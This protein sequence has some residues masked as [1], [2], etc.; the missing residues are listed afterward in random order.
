M[1]RGAPAP[2]IPASPH[3]NAPGGAFS[4]GGP[5]QPPWLV[6]FL[7]GLLLAAIDVTYGVLA[8][9]DRLSSL[10]VLSTTFLAAAA[11]GAGAYLALWYGVVRRLRRLRTMPGFA[12]SVALCVLLTGLTLALSSL[13]RAA[14]SGAL[15]A[16]SVDAVLAL[17]LFGALTPAAYRAASAIEVRPERYRAIL[18]AAAVAPLVA[19]AT[20]FYVWFQTYVLRQADDPWV[21]SAVFA[22]YLAVAGI[23]IRLALGSSRGAKV[24]ANTAALAVI[25]AISAAS[26]FPYQQVPASA[27]AEEPR[28]AGQPPDAPPVV[29]ITVDTLR[30]GAVS[31]YNP[32]ARSTPNIDALAADGVRFAN[33]LAP[34]GWTLP[35]MATLFTGQ[36]P[37]VHGALWRDSRIPDALDTLAERM[38]AAGYWTAGMGCNPYLTPKHDFTQ[39][40]IE[41][42]F[43]PKDT[44]FDDSLAARLIHQVFEPGPRSWVD[45]DYLTQRA[46]DWLDAN[47]ERQFF[48]WLHYLG[49]HVPY[50]PDPDLLPAEPARSGIGPQ[51]WE[52]P[53]V[54]S[55]EKILNRAERQWLRTLYGAEAASIDRRIGTVVAKLK[56]LGLYDD[57]LIVLAS[58]HGEEFWEH[59]GFEHGHTLYQELLEVPP[60][61][62][63]GHARDPAGRDAVD[64]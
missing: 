64:P 41:Y 63:R 3:K 59:G 20:M 7:L 40:F 4:H 34:S 44:A 10:P 55:G 5:Q 50:T 45:S 1:P 37:A 23:A 16:E 57:A 49:P 61:R 52:A 6:A 60:G 58:D 22:G 25:L 24:A 32:Q 62:G 47:R 21:N 39:G 53:L 51:F 15:P 13:S 27:G 42:D 29:L 26:G 36:P 19:A 54:R 56:S 28:V 14:A 8:L 46:V 43:Y 38:A 35:S 31:S 48:F 33:A 30:A 12:A 18:G 9:S 17:A 11:A 2:P